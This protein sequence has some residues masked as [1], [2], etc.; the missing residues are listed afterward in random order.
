MTSSKNL[1]AK[2]H[3]AH[4]SAISA[5][6]DPTAIHTSI[7]NLV[8]HAFMSEV[9]TLS[10]MNNIIDAVCEGI[11]NFDNEK[12]RSTN[13]TLPV[14]Q[15][16]AYQGLYS[17][18]CEGLNATG[19]AHA[20]FLRNGNF[21]VSSNFKRALADETL[22]LK[23][24]LDQI[25]LLADWQAEFKAKNDQDKWLQQLSTPITANANQ[26]DKSI[27]PWVDQFFQICEFDS[28][29]NSEHLAAQFMLL[30]L[31]TS[32]VLAGMRSCQTTL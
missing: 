19:L 13:A 28:I 20:E 29:K 17:A 3:A 15:R 26:H 5:F 18:A 11:G 25:T 12:T 16:S 24:Q 27:L 22:K 31:F 23:R 10:R 32:G 9:L 8:L 7:Y 2:E 21:S 6:A 1:Q 14:L 4:V 30:G